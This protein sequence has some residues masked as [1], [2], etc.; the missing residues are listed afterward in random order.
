MMI[1]EIKEGDIEGV[2]R[3]CLDAFSDSVAGSLSDEGIATFTAIAS[4]NAFAERMKADNRMLVA[5]DNNGEILG[6]V[7]LKEGRHIA[8]LF[9]T[10][11]QQKGGIGRRL[12]TA[13]LKY[14]R[15][16]T[17]TV[18]ASLPSVPAYRKYGFKLT[19]DVGESS[20]L[21]YQPME[22]PTNQKVSPCL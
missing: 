13:A 4:P 1:R 17:V 7:E 10:P 11:S 12:L 15:S 18:S 6:V 9:V 14:A 20:G 16:E 22:V 8:M 3:V 19:G 21:V 5:E 2:S